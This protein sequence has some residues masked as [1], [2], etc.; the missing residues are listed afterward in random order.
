MTR[1]EAADIIDRFARDDPKM[2]AWDWDD[3]TCPGVYQDDLITRVV[4]ECNEI[5]NKY[6]ANGR[7]YCNE[8]GTARLLELR[9]EL[10]ASGEPQDDLNTDSGK[11]GI[12]A[13]LMW[14][15]IFIVGACI[16]GG[17]ILWIVWMGLLLFLS[18]CENEIKRQVE[19]PDNEL[20]AIVFDRNCGATV[21]HNA[22]LSVIARNDSLAN[23][24]GNVFI[25]D[26]G[27][28]GNLEVEAIWQSPQKLLIVHDPKARVFLNKSSIDVRTGIF[29]VKHVTIVYR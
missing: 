14:L 21:G 8:Q 3:F 12:W 16:V 17:G 20:K 4:E 29:S 11:Q 9:D 25:E 28:G 6:P 24:G 2:G 5:Y 10:L 23:D 27:E 15:P 13:T 22:Q 1:A 7:G 26:I 19:S 18:P